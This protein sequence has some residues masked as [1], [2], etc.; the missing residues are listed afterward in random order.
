MSRRG[1]WLAP[2]F[3]QPRFPKARLEIRPLLLAVWLGC[4]AVAPNALSGLSAA[5]DM[6]AVG[7][8]LRDNAVDRGESGPSATAAV[9][10]TVVA[11]FEP[12][13][14]QLEAASIFPLLTLQAREG[15]EDLRVV[16][17]WVRHS[18][19][20][21]GD[22][23]SLVMAASPQLLPPGAVNSGGD[24]DHSH[25]FLADL[26]CRDIGYASP[27][28]AHSYQA[29]AGYLPSAGVLGFALH[30]LTAGRLVAK[31]W[32]ALAR[33]GVRLTPQVQLYGSPQNSL[34]SS[35]PWQVYPGFVPFGLKWGL[36][37]NGVVP[38]EERRLSG[39]LDRSLKSMLWWSGLPEGAPVCGKLR[40]SVV[41]GGLVRTLATA[42][43]SGGDQT[44]PVDSKWLPA[45]VFELQLWFE[46]VNH[47]LWLLDEGQYV[48]GK[49]TAEARIS[50]FHPSKERM[51]I[52]G[53]LV[54][55]SDGPVNVQRVNL[56][57]QLNNGEWLDS[58]I[59][60]D[61]ITVDGKY[62]MP[63][64][65]S[66]P[67]TNPSVEPGN[68]GTNIMQL[69]VSPAISLPAGV[70]AEMRQQSVYLV[71]S[72]EPM[73]SVT[74][75]G[76]VVVHPIE[77]PRAFRNPL[78]GI[79]S[80]GL[81]VPEPLSPLDVVR[82]PM[83]PLSSLTK[84]YIPWNALEERASDGVDK[85]RAFSEKL[86]GS[87]PHDI[88]VIPRVILQWGPQGEEKYWPSDL[89]PGDYGSAEFKQR[90]VKLI[91]K[92]G[93]AWDQD[94]HVAYVEM[95]LIG[96]W[97]EHHHPAI[98]PELQRLIGDTFLRSFPHKLVMYRNPANFE[99]YP[100]GVH[101]DSFAHPDEIGSH[102]PLIEMQGDLWK[103]APRGGELTCDWGRPMAASVTDAILNHTDEIVY[104][105][106]RLHWNHLGFWPDMYD[107][108]NDALERNA[109][110]IHKAL[111]YR[112]VIREA[113]Y[114]ARIA[115]GSTLTLSLSVLNTGS[116]P[117]YYNWPV[118]VYLLDLETGKVVW[119]QPWEGVD[120]RQWLPGGGF[121]K[122][123]PAVYNI[124]GQW[125]L[126]A[127]LDP[128]VYI[129]AIGILDPGW[130]E[131]QLRFAVVNHLSNNLCPLGKIGIDANIDDPALDRFVDLRTGDP[132]YVTLSDPSEKGGA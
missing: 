94:P 105:I 59:V 36:A 10:W 90:L 63:F 86:W 130:N 32:V 75:D 56:K 22:V 44:M 98:S 95:G 40:L 41:Q 92:L 113:R 26:V 112:F 3:K 120:I 128:G 122:V 8:N 50:S 111:G 82:T 125:A 25:A 74:E 31:A 28:T 114:P 67:W 9:P 100:F 38:G 88:K 47:H 108:T 87:L 19:G 18:A 72:P 69:T 129:L 23:W 97:G 46:D 110:E 93:A 66:C 4:L 115:P 24:A 42:P 101:W 5:P 54:I 117:F 70:V 81:E 119:S 73:Y 13:P 52:Q 43:Y 20:W 1:Y 79:R 65:A 71:A 64:T 68:G 11:V 103:R 121:P 2:G 127:T 58:P 107:W 124:S 80:L 91:Q 6:Q 62:T 106:R 104:W 126:P 76:Y 123:E 21:I 27:D 83:N 37:P 51:T 17:A 89:E 34:T 116:S 99:G 57:L 12:P 7:A 33:Q 35:P 84:V 85:I 16:F 132:L 30:D 29:S 61:P 78:K 77:Y 55:T 109:E 15:R 39:S 48:A 45:G 60:S 118:M 14:A 53:D 49:V 102:V 96:W 131:P